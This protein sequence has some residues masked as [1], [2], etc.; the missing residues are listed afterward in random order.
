MLRKI[1]LSTGMFA[2]LA[3]GVSQW[4]M[5]RPTYQQCFD[6]QD[7]QLAVCATYPPGPIQ[8]VCIEDAQWCYISCITGR[9]CFP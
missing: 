3:L 9:G 2:V 6:Q 5:A 1:I 7:A 8:D 4:L